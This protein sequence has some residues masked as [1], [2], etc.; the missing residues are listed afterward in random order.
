MYWKMIYFKLH[1]FLPQFS[2]VKK[3]Y[4]WDLE[5]SLLRKQSNSEVQ[6]MVQQKVLYLFMS[7]LKAKGVLT[8]GL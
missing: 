6:S 7:K 4:L 8:T 1:L 5:Q 2:F 3:M